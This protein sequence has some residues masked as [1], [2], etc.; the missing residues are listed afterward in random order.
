MENIK[1]QIITYLN[2]EWGYCTDFI[3]YRKAHY[4]VGL[5]CEDMETGMAQ[6]EKELSS[7]KFDNQ[8]MIRI[9]STLSKM[10]IIQYEHPDTD[11]N[12]YPDNTGFLDAY[13]QKGE[14]SK[15]NNLMPLSDI[16][17][18]MDKFTK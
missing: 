18:T 1:P 15:L 9:V 7:E 5:L 12:L 11:L 17:T 16:L 2:A 13:F 6:I 8:N 14:I 3:G 10:M 4:L